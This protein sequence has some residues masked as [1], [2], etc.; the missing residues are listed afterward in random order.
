MTAADNVISTTSRFIDD[1]D[2]S[3]GLGGDIHQDRRDILEGDKLQEQQQHTTVDPQLATGAADEVG[4]TLAQ[5]TSACSKAVASSSFRGGNEGEKLENHPTESD[6]ETSVRRDGAQPQ[7]PPPNVHTTAGLTNA[8]SGAAEEYPKELAAAEAS[9]VGV[10]LES[11]LGREDQDPRVEVPIP[12]SDGGGGLATDGSGGSKPNVRRASHG[13]DNDNTVNDKSR[14][15]PPAP[16]EELGPNTNAEGGALQNDSETAPG[17]DCNT[18]QGRETSS[19]QPYSRSRSDARRSIQEGENEPSKGDVSSN[20]PKPNVEISETPGSSRKIGV[21]SQPARPSN[22]RNT[23]ESGGNDSGSDAKPRSLGI[24]ATFEEGD[25]EDNNKFLQS[26][27]MLSR[28]RSSRGGLES[29][30]DLDKAVRPAE[31]FPVH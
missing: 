8:S 13:D 20:A 30:V 27:P 5:E 31:E 6:T 7:S 12:S 9:A 29:N 25:V 22:R 16:M 23:L 24:D 18:T 3:Q 28:R 17:T 10:R 21:G 15:T 14:T 1:F 2:Q 19:G 4:A 11:E 26:P